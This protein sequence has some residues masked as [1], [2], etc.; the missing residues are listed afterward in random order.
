[1]GTHPTKAFDRFIQIYRLKMERVTKQ[2][3]NTLI[4]G[5]GFESYLKFLFYQ[6]FYPIIMKWKT[7][8]VETSY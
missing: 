4:I 3:Y 7:I 5:L 2:V 6:V 8:M 1:M